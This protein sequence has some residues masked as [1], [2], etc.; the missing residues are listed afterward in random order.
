MVSDRDMGM[1]AWVVYENLGKK[2]DLVELL[3]ITRPGD[4]YGKALERRAYRP[5]RPSVA[6]N[7]W[8]EYYTAKLGRVVKPTWKDIEKAEEEGVKTGVI[9]Y[10]DSPFLFVH[11]VPEGYVF[12]LYRYRGRWCLGSGATPVSMLPVQSRSDLRPPRGVSI[13]QKT[14]EYVR[15]VM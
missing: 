1:L 15:G 3:G 12:G 8:A 4:I 7:V 10:G 11:N 13:T 2:A 14:K 9:R 6:K 5:L